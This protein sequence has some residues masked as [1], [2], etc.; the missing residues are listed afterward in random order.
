MAPANESLA[1]LPADPINGGVRSRLWPIVQATLFRWSLQN[2]Y[3]FRARLLRLFGADLAAEARVRPTVRIDNPSMLTMGRKSSIGDG[4][5]LWAGAPISIGA[6]SVLSQYTLV[7]TWRVDPARIEMKP[8]A[9]PITVGDDAWVA[10]E[11]VLVAG[12][13]VPDGVVVGARSVI[14]DQLEPWTIATGAPARSRRQR[15]PW[16][17]IPGE[18]ASEGA[19]THHGG[20]SDDD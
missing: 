17:K 13:V 14:E 2:A 20:G 8:E 1:S 12:A 15:P 3:R 7:N 10:T 4:C 19:E 18:A 6:R 16:K 5:E 11:S 9:F